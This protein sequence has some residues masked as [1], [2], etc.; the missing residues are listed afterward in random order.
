MQILYT[1]ICFSLSL[2]LQLIFWHTLHVLWLQAGAELRAPS[3]RDEYIEKLSDV[4]YVRRHGAHKLANLSH[5]L[6][7]SRVEK[8]TRV[9]LP[10][11]HNSLFRTA[12][13]CRCTI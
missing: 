12:N 5:K 13:C 6:K 7:L 8:H 4:Y 10:N 9:C 3:T 2:H 1:A 11:F